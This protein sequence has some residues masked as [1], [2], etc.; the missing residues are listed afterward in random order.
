M[1]HVVRILIVLL[2]V[3]GVWSIA[4]DKTFGQPEPPAP[5]PIAT[6]TPPAPAT[7]TPSA[8]PAPATSQ[9]PAAQRVQF[10]R[11]A[12]GD[13]IRGEGRGQYLLWAAQG[14][15]LTVQSV[16]GANV[17]IVL[18]VDGGQPL[19]FGDVNGKPGA[20]LPVSGDYLLDVAAAGAFAVAVEIR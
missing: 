18:S 15:V 14:Q 8:T 10:P 20:R 6:V 12:W 13:T 1:G 2:A 4:V 17:G 19:Q 9:A 5:T 7:P 11:G 16:T 3:Y